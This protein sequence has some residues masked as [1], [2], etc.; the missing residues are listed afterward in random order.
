MWQS[1]PPSAAFP[2]H[3]S[4]LAGVAVLNPAS[5]ACR[6]KP[7]SPASAG[8]TGSS[9]PPTQTT[10]PI[11]EGCKASRIFPR[12][13]GPRFDPA[14]NR[15]AKDVQSSERSFSCVNSQLLAQIIEK[16]ARL[17]CARQFFPETLVQMLANQGDIHS[18]FQQ[19]SGMRHIF[20]ASGKT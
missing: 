11:L 12:P 2:F 15:G 14:H 16:I 17:L 3:A 1:L 4:S 9:R 18:L 13:T 20:F 8:P 5:D 19:L 10:P 6:N 7:V